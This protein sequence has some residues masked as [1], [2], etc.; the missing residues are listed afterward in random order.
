MQSIDN[1]P[2]NINID[3]ASLKTQISTIDDLL[4]QTLLCTSAEEK[5]IQPIL[6]N[7]MKTA[8]DLIGIIRNELKELETSYTLLNES[9]QRTIRKNI[10]TSLTNRFMVIIREYQEKQTTFKTKFEDRIKR[11]M[12]IVNPNVTEEELLQA[13]EYGDQNVFSD[14]VLHTH[15][16]IDDKHKKILL[17]VDMALLVDSQGELIDTI[18]TNVNQTQ[19]YTKHAVQEL[20]QANTYQRGSRKKICLIVCISLFVMLA[21][22][23]TSVVATS[24]RK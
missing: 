20:K 16:Y 23:V 8:N 3:I 2:L 5:R 6:E 12:K 1:L 10:H 11:Q 19:S 21:I 9:T 17:L 24:Y 22:V 13:I 15:S 7:E 18:E 4:S 14:H